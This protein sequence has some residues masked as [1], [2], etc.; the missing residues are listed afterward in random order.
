M[1]ITGSACLAFLLI[2]V[3]NCLGRDLSKDYLNSPVLVRLSGGQEASGFYVSDKTNVFFV[4]ARHVF[5]DAS[6]TNLIGDSCTLISWPEDLSRRDPVI[7]EL[8]LRTLLDSKRLRCLTNQDIAVARVATLTT[9][10]FFVTIPN[11]VTW[12]RQSTTRTSGIGMMPITMFQTFENA[13]EGNEI[14]LFGYPSSLGM[15]QVPQIEHDKPLLRRGILAGKNYSKKLLILD[16]SVYYGNSGG[17][18]IILNRDNLGMIVY[19]LIG[20]VSQFVPF[21]EV[22]VN[23]KHGIRNYQLSNSGYAVVSSL[24]DVS[25]LMHEME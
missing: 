24:D 4:T 25:T 20:V 7:M 6:C 15:E 2:V 10:G 9:N 8:Q 22:W 12:G 17:P 14:Y 23:T 18:V 16:A 3:S 21:E 19:S 13:A 11:E 1:K 5:F